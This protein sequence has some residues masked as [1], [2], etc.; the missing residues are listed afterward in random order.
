MR[1]Y[2]TKILFK[3]VFFFLFSVVLLLGCSKDSDL[4]LDSVINDEEI[5]SVEEKEKNTPQV[6]ETEEE[7]STEE[8]TTTEEPQSTLES[9]TTS[10]SPT[11]DAHFQSGKAYN[12]SIIRLD[13]GNRTS[14]LMFDLSP[15]S[16]IA[17]DITAATLQF[18]IDSDTGSGNINVFKANSSNW[19]EDN[20]SDGNIPQIEVQVGSII[21]EY[22]L[23]ATELVELNASELSPEIST[24]I[25]NHKNGNDLAF[26]SKEHPSKIGPKLVISYNVDQGKEEI[27]IP[28]EEDTSEETTE[29]DTTEEDTA[30]NQEPI[31]V[32]DASPSN[33]GVP[34][35]VSFSGSNSSDDTGITNFSWDF[36]DGSTATTPNPT[37]TYT[38]TG[39]YEAVLTVTDTEGLTTTDTVTITIGETQNEAPKAIINAT[40]ASGEAPLEVTFKGSTSTDDHSISSY[41]WNFKDGSQT[42]LADL[43]HTYNESGTYDAELTVTDENGLSD[44]KTVSIVVTEPTNAAPIAKTSANTTLGTAPLTVQFAGNTSSD[45]KG[46]TAY[47][48][49]FKDGSNASTANPSHSFTNAGTYVVELTVSDQEGLTHKNTITITVTEPV[50]E[51]EAPV[52]TLSANITSGEAPLAVQFTGSQSSDD[53]AITSYFWDFKDG[54]TSTNSNP[55][56]TFNSAGSY[57]VELTVQDA[58][59]ASDTKSIA[60]NA[61]PV[62]NNSPPG[63][64]VATNGNTSNNGQSPSSPWSLEHAFSVAKAGDIIYIK[65]GNY[66][67]KNLIIYNSGNSGNPIKFIGYTNTPGDL[68]SSQGSTFNYGD[69]LNAN[70]M[71]LLRGNSSLSGLALDLNGSFVEVHNF[72][73][74]NYQTGI[75]TKGRNITLKNVIVTNNGEQNNNNSQTGKGFQILGD[76]TILQDCFNLNSNAEGINIKGANNCTVKNTKVYSDN[77]ANPGGYYIAVTFG[78]SNNVIEDCLIYRSKTADLHRG[79]GYIMKDQ[80]TNNIVRRSIAYNTGIEVNY[81]GVSYNTFDDVKLYGSYSEDPNEFSSGIRVIN[82]AHHNTFRNIYIKDSRYPF[83]FHDFDDGFVGPG[84]DRDLAQGGNNNEFIN[85]VTEGS[86]SL[87]FCNTLDTPLGQSTSSGNTWTNCTFSNASSVPFYSTH[88]TSNFRFIGCTFNNISGTTISQTENGVGSW[89]ASYQNSTFN[90]VNFPIPN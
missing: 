68:V 31:A 88:Q 76:N 11:N 20:L 25:L 2:P 70:K 79:H 16:D 34:L 54:S 44:T 78:G 55:A 52:A 32:A 66:G 81:S 50:A 23:G 42:N 13:E 62:S 28:E 90:N 37:H 36:K 67:N 61:T 59:G 65:A 18:T 26:A 71:P 3:F 22:K 72:Q 7:T 5:S 87:V 64:Y 86:N 33:G 6:S 29:E 83:N 1:F 48:W 56:H 35:E 63:F 27:I 80:A 74:T 47:S 51:N 60:I 84:G 17:G 75:L 43:K 10:F 57:T 73:I 69:A 41:S 58:D 15:I 8:E 53:K 14:Y 21:K 40:P 89:N 82:G 30:T 49:D 85:V 9:R 77:H 45:D 19:S 4:L 39:V 38:A 24:L 46:I 12:Q